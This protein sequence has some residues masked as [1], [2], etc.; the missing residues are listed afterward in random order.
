VT[1]W[2]TASKKLTGI[3]A[4][5]AIGKAIHRIFPSF[6]SASLDIILQETI[7]HQKPKRLIQK[8]KSDG[9][10]FLEIKRLS[11]QS[12]GSNLW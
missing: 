10:P 3:D 9:E 2:N 12:W 8:L 4:H 7:K 1:Y 6:Q 5:Q 11:I